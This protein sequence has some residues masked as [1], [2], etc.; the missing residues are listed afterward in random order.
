MTESPTTRERTTGAAP[1]ETVTPG[2]AAVTEAVVDLSRRYA[3]VVVAGCFALTVL[4]GW[5][6]ATHLGIDAQT[7]NL[8]D[9]TLPWRQSEAEI[10]RLFP[11]HEG[12]L[13]IVIDGATPEIADD[14][15]ARNTVKAPF[16]TAVGKHIGIAA[17]TH[18]RHAEN[19]QAHH[20]QQRR[21]NTQRFPLAGRR[22]CK[23]PLHTTQRWLRTDK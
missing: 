9:P 10:R 23:P 22:R 18:Q 21:R 3:Q 16:E 19:D 1:E 14:A 15:A 12:A 20:A 7:E 2:I 11:Q 8:I 5:Y 17:A 6:M 13:A 4:F